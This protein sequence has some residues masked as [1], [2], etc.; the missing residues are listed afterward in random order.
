MKTLKLSALALVA[1]L[2]FA[3]TSCSDDD[4]TP[5]QPAPADTSITALAVATPQLSTLV[6]ALTKAGLTDTF[7]NPGTYTVFAPTNDAFSAFLTAN[8]FANLDAVPLPLLTEV[9]KNHVLTSRLAST[10]LTTGYVKT[11]AK[12][13]ASTNTL[14]MFVNTANSKVILNGGAEVKTPNIAA[15]NG[16][17][18]IVDKV[19][20]LPSIVDHAKANPLLSLLVKVVT[21]TVTNGNGFGDQSAVATALTTNTTPLTVF[22]PIDAAF[23]TATTAPGFATGA[24]GAPVTKVLQYHVVAGN[25]LAASLQNDTELTT[26]ATNPADALLQKLRVF[27]NAPL[28]ARLQDKATA[29]NNISK[30]IATD[31]QCTNG[32]VHAIDKVLQPNL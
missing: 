17:I 9:L 18:H 22:A 24:T 26:I 6:Q 28:G 14:S 25:N 27:T 15:S 3:T 29:P 7:K 2:A 20:G 21:S 4:A 11:L 16:I 13:A 12:G 19:I 31:I 8:N 1:F 5:V 32:V 30:I 23:V 10:A